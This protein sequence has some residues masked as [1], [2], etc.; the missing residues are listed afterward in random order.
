MVLIGAIGGSVGMIDPCAEDG[1][2]PACGDCLACGQV[3]WVS[4]AP[5]VVPAAP[6][7][8]GLVEPEAV[9]PTP[10]PRLVDHVPLHSV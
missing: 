6:A 2:P 9:G 4:V 1:C 5:V 3:A 8:S 7:R 10:P